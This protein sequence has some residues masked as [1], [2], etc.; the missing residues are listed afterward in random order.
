MAKMNPIIPLEYP[1]AVYQGLPPDRKAARKE[2][3][4]RKGLIRKSYQEYRE[5]LINGT[6]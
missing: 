5:R 4:R 2:L 6:S 1:P 3:E